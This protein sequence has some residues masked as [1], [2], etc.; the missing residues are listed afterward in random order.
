M[1]CPALSARK[2]AAWI[3]GPSA[4]GSVNGMPS[5]ITSAPAF[6]SALAI[7]S[8]VV[9]VGIARHGE[10]HQRGAAFCFSAAKRRVD[11]GGQ[12][13]PARA[14]PLQRASVAR[15]TS[16]SGGAHGIG[17]ASSFQMLPRCEVLVAAAGEID[18][19]QVILR[20]LR[21]EIEHAGER[22]RRLE[23]RDDAFELAAQAGTPPRASS[24]VAERNFTRPISL[25]Q[26]CSGPMP[27]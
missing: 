19:H 1:V 7:A 22:V 9:V 20:L 21:R 10:G 16:V 14:S 15:M 5:S 13:G 25:S 3:A 12:S 6:G 8:E 4:I 18:H 2:P 24:S 27:G 17:A 11:A 23:R 26:A